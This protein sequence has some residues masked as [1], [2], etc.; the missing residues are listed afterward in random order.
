MPLTNDPGSHG[1]TPFHCLLLAFPVALFPSGLLAD[2]TYLNSAVMQWSHFAAWLIAGATFFASLVLIWT[3]VRFI[4]A[5]KLAARDR[6]LLYLILVAVMWA[7]GLVNSFKHSQDGWS[8]V[9]TLG[10]TLSVISTI[11][12]LAAGIVGYGTASSRRSGR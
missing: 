3:V 9:G 11:A 10:L 12:A 5:R 1:L 8:S 2:I 4:R 6:G 7:S